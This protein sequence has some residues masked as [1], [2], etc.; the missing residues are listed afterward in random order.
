MI[1][2]IRIKDNKKFYKKTVK[3]GCENIEFL[4]DGITKRMLKPIK[5]IKDYEDKFIECYEIPEEFRGVSFTL[6]PK[7]T[8]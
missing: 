1:E 3:I 5:N 6:K 4:C 7:K 8:K 2:V